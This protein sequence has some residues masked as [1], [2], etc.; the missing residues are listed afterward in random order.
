MKILECP[1]TWQINEE[2]MS[3]F[4]ES[5]ELIIDFDEE[6]L[7]FCIDT[8]ITAYLQAKNNCNEQAIQKMK[9]LDDYYWEKPDQGWV[10]F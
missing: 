6:P 3:E 10:F 9:V 1:F 7:F 2:L 4:N 5:Q 8:M